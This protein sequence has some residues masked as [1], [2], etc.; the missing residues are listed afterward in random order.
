[1]GNHFDELFDQWANSYDQ[2]VTGHDL[3]YRDVFLHYDDILQ[4]VADRAIGHVLEFGPGTGNLTVKLI[5]KG[6]TVIGVEPSGEMRKIVLEKVAGRA[7][8]IEGHFFHFPQNLTV[9]TI[10]STYAFHHLTDGEKAEAIATYR[11]ILPSGGKIVF[12]DTMY[13]TVNSYQKAIRDASQKGFHDLAHNLQSEYY[14]T[15]PVLTAILNHNGFDVE[16]EQCND[17]VW[18]ME[19]IKR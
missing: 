12:A 5:N 19:G 6:L 15:I 16:F 11:N 9:Q 4:Q 18:I 3:E 2:T 7:K 8:I 10:T 14:T 17:F 1:M 13:E